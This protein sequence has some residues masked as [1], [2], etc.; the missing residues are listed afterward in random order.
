[1]WSACRSFYYA[2]VF[3]GAMELFY[4]QLVAGQRPD[5]GLFDRFLIQCMLF[6]HAVL[7]SPSYKGTTGAYQLSSAARA[8]VSHSPHLTCVD[9]QLQRSH[10]SY[11]FEMH[12]VSE[13]VWSCALG[14]A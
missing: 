1:M 12:G 2:G 11:F 3:D 13:A 8:Q 5:G 10:A 14:R 7:T 9:M 4:S 6:H